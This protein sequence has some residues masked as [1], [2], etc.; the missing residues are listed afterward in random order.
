MDDKKRTHHDYRTHNV[1]VSLSEEEY[2]IYLENVKNSGKK[3]T[4]FCRQ[5]LTEMRATQRINPEDAKKINQLSKLGLDIHRLLGAA[6]KE[7]LTAHVKWLGQ[8]ELQFK[9]LY[10]SINTLV[11]D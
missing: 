11:D 10:Q 3:K 8:I 2:K 6:Y 4:D 1:S 5:L 7:G 9:E